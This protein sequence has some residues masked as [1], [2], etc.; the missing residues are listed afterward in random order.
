MDMLNEEIEPLAIQS[1]Q[2]RLTFLVDAIAVIS[3]IDPGVSSVEVGLLGGG[4][5]G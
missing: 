5:A 4:L 1:Q 3:V 2:Y